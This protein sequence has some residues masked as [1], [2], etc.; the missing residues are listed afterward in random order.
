MENVTEEEE[1]GER[2]R[3]KLERTI[4][5]TVDETK[6]EREREREDH[7]QRSGAFQL[8]GNRKQNNSFR[9]HR[10]VFYFTRAQTD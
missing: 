5:L 1:Q 3:T 9:S 7:V 2:G 4:R 6:R 10:Y 8:P